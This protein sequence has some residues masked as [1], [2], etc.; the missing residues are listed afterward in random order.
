MPLT[1]N[2]WFSFKITFVSV[3]VSVRRLI[4]VTV[5]T[6]V[7]KS[8]EVS[9]LNIVTVASCV[10]VWWVDNINIFF[11][12]LGKINSN[13]EFNKVKLKIKKITNQLTNCTVLG[14]V[15]VEVNL[16]TV[17]TKTSLTTVRVT[18]M[19]SWTSSDSLDEIIGSCSTKLSRKTSS[20]W[21][22]LDLLLCS[23]PA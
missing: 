3:L 19:H 11:M 15:T 20:E 22:S 21:S 18:G 4:S 12:N 5:F 14:T 7:R 23:S 16:M 2:I 17:G 13:L 1:Y 9:S 6:N 8:V 10:V